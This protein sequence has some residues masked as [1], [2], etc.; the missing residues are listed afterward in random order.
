V[1]H[2]FSLVSVQYSPFFFVL[3]VA[4]TA[5]AAAV[6]G[7]V[8]NAEDKHIQTSKSISIFGTPSGDNGH[9]EFETMISSRFLGSTFGHRA[10]GVTAERGTGH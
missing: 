9:C 1:R 10:A 4:A 3:A 7:Q 8:D 2:A 6:A 5:G